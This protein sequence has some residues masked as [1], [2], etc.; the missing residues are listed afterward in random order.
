MTAVPILL[1]T[2]FLG[3]GK[4][5]LINRLLTAPDG[6]RLA[7]I[8]NDFGA[9]DIDAALLAE[10]ADG[11][12]SLKNGCIC[13]S[14]QGDLLRSLHLILRRDPAP[15]GIVIETSGVSDPAEI[16][17]ALLDPAIFRAAA[18]DA[19]VGVADARQLADQPALFNDA[20]CR[21]QLRAADFVALSKTDLLSQA[22][23]A[24]IRTRLGALKPARMIFDV[25]HGR[26]AP[27]LLFGAALHR[28]LPPAPMRP[29][30]ASPG[31][32]TMSWTAAAPLT[33]AR[34]QAA[35]GQLAGVLVRAKGIVRFAEQPER[36][37]LFQLVG[38]RAT[39][40]PGP[41]GDA[42]SEPVRLVLIARGGALDEAKIR[43]MLTQCLASPPP[44][45]QR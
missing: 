1:A 15:D 14:L 33:L 39:L 16:V 44:H 21:A 13:C 6:R 43:D 22:E 38:Q 20:L 3:A 18:L 24:A 11:V 45:A 41:A 17:R 25:E 12:V 37:M 35:I 9:I 8:V 5:T 36:P 31:F 42:A 4:T 32:E 23:A 19:I 27:E 10:A 7:A 34:F 26:I 30:L 2:G 28:P 40:S 29:G